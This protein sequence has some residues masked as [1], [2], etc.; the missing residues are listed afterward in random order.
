MLVWISSNLELII[1]FFLTILIFIPFLKT[2]K[3]CEDEI[4]HQSHNLNLLYDCI[5]ENEKRAREFYDTQCKI[6]PSLLNNEV[7]MKTE[8]DLYNIAVKDYNERFFIPIKQQNEEIKERQ[9]EV[10]D[11]RKNEWKSLWPFLTALGLMWL[12][13][14]F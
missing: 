8:I 3:A 10:F 1:K 12:G 4:K 6:D 9:K 5:R 14:K 13:V 2:W 11:L 7:T